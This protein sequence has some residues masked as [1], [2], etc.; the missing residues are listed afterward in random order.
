MDERIELIE[1]K[2]IK[3]AENFRMAGNVLMNS[4]ECCI[5]NQMF[6]SQIFNA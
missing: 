4:K 3:D 6:L 1:C 2:L 5:E